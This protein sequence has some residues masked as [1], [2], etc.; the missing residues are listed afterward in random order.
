M[1]GSGL[2]A[3]APARYYTLTSAEKTLSMYTHTHTH[4]HS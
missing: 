4:T 1:R 2:E 3:D